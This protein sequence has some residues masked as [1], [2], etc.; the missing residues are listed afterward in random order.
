MSDFID[1]EEQKRIKEE[2]RK[3]NNDKVKRSYG[4]RPNKKPKPKKIDN[5]PAK[6]IP[7]KRDNK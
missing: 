1:P 2:E 3:Q 6:V 5:A 7:F 4:I